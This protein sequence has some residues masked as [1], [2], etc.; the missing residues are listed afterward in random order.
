MLFV[1][2]IGFFTRLLELVAT[3]IGAGILVGGF[4][5]AIGGWSRKAVEGDS[6][7]NGFYGGVA[8]LV[9]LIADS[10]LR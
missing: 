5:G 10:C 1:A 6:L 7:K 4:V 2:Q 9:C 8:G 3:A